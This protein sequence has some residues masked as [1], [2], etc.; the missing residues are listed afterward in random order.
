MYQ[1]Y[2]AHWQRGISL[3]H[4]RDLCQLGFKFGCSPSITPGLAPAQGVGERLMVSVPYTVGDP[5]LLSRSCA[6]SQRQIL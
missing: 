1:K 4:E 3:E 6:H 5:F 2:S